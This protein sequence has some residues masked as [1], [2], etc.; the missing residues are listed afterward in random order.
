MSLW[1]KGINIIVYGTII[2]PRIFET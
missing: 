2:V 1:K